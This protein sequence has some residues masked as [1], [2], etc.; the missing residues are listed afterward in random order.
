MCKWNS[1]LYCWVLLREWKE[2]FCSLV[3]GVVAEDDCFRYSLF[4]VVHL[5]CLVRRLPF[6]VCSQAQRENGISKTII[7]VFSFFKRNEKKERIPSCS[8]NPSFWRKFF[9][10]ASL[11]LLVNA[12]GIFWCKG[13]TTKSNSG[14]KQKMTC[15]F[16]E[17]HVWK[18]KIFSIKKPFFS[19]LI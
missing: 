18:K 6:E 14:V 4:A 17:S 13:S 11:H 3:V 8:S 16:N 5:W 2:S 10:Y 15:F 7:N 1:G 9:L 12:L 19:T